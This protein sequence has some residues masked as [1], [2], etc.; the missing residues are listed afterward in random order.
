MPKKQ[1]KEQKNSA[2]VQSIIHKK[3]NNCSKLKQEQIR[4]KEQKFIIK[5]IENSQ[6]IKIKKSDEK[7]DV[8]IISLNIKATI[9]SN[10]LNTNISEHNQH[11]NDHLD[12]LA[13]LF[14]ERQ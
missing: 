8:D 3:K 11:Q 1:K 2:K 14:G 6:R 5:S 10:E 4:Q 7:E 12:L 13:E 9:N